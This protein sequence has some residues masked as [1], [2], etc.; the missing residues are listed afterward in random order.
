MYLIIGV[1]TEPEKHVKPFNGLISGVQASKA[2]K[3]VDKT[4]GM[5]SYVTIYSPINGFLLTA[6]LAN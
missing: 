6:N 5:A 1:Y 3:S 2:T 4:T